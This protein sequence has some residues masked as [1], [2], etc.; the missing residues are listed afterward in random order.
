MVS[1]ALDNA[2]VYTSIFQLKRYNDSVIEKS[3]VGLIVIDSRS[4]IATMNTRSL[5]I[6]DLNKEQIQLLGENDKP[7]VFIDLLPDNEKGRWEYMISTA[8]E[9]KEDFSNDRYFHN[10]G[11]IEKVLS[12]KISPIPQLT[13]GSAGLIMTVEDITDKVLMEKYVILSEKLVAKGEMAASVAHELN[14][15]LAIAS[16]NAELLTM[17]IERNKLD[18]VKFNCK[19]IVLKTR[20]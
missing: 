11:Y 9:T 18:K 3:P 1:N 4:R 16:N 15:Y 10:T 14:N 5:E 19:S 2:N 20:R 8:L 7:S 17:N 12:I 6:F 13:N